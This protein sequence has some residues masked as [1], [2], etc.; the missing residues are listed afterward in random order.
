MLILHFGIILG[1]FG[2]HFGVNLGAFWGHLGVILEPLARSCDRTRKNSPSGLHLEASWSQLER[3][4]EPRW[5]QDGQLGAQDGLLGAQDGQLGSILG[6]VLA[7]LS[8][9]GA[10]F[11]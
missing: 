3:S 10:N 4:W 8:H 9:L 6:A 1:S 7:R 5:R 11:I 2:E